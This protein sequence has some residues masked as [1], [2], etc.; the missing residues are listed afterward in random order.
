M[1]KFKE[2][3]ST[4]YRTHENCVAILLNHASMSSLDS[5]ERAPPGQL[6][7]RERTRHQ[8]EGTL[9]CT[10]RWGTEHTYRCH[11]LAHI[12]IYIYVHEV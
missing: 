7:T 12:Y 2:K 1:S 6:P 10:S 5:I 4:V 8:N 3:T 9:D 11:I